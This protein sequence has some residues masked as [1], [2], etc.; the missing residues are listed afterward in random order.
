MS[1][2]RR[3]ALYLECC[4]NHG[5]HALL[6]T[7]F[8]LMLV[9]FADIFKMLDDL[10]MSLQSPDMQMIL[11]GEER[12]GLSTGNFTFA[13]ENVISINVEEKQ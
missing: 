12:R 13:E 5:V 10:N 6:E 1:T 8:L 9:Y 4:S 2:S 7:N 3:D 11:L